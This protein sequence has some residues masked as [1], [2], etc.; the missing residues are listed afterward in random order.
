MSR[1]G[2]THSVKE[3]GLER[4]MTILRSIGGSEG[5]TFFL[6]KKHM[7]WKKR[8]EMNPCHSTNIELRNLR[9][10]N[11]QQSDYI[12]HPLNIIRTDPCTIFVCMDFAG[13]DLFDYMRKPFKWNCMQI[14]LG[15]IREA[16]HFLHNNG[17][18][19][20]DIKPENVIFQKGIPKLID[21]DFSSTLDNFYYC[22]SANYMMDKL[23]V[24]NWTCSNIIKSKRMDIYA[25]GKLVFSVLL[26]AAQFPQHKSFL[27]Y[28][29]F[30]EKFLTNPYKGERGKWANIAVQCCKCRPP[31]QIPEYLNIPE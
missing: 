5:S 26:S 13:P 12:L 27:L 8:T 3:H 30:N 20:R 11:L 21:W 22:G 6:D 16:I 19:H 17:I 15:H 10:M 4:K 9:I 2:C 14:Y 31:E 29:F 1:M 25:F 18:A 28:A 23:T 24:D 7:L